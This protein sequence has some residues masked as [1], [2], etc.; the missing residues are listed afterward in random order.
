MLFPRK[1]KTNR[2][3]SINTSSNSRALDTELI[4]SQQNRPIKKVFLIVQVRRDHQYN[5]LTGNVSGIVRWL[6][7]LKSVKCLYIS[8]Y[9]ATWLLG[10]TTKR[11]VR[12]VGVLVG[13][14]SRR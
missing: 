5:N 10:V 11:N 7:D 3:T 14:G 2:L 9:R 13:P 1:K 8:D 4:E 12:T 6:N